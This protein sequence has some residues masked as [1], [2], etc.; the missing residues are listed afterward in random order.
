MRA[1]QKRDREKDMSMGVS[2][3]GGRVARAFWIAGILSSALAWASVGGSISGTVKD[4]T[5]RVIPGADVTAREVNTGLVYRARTGGDGH[6]ALPVLP[7]GQYELA[8]QAAG[9]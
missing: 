3:L 1:S 6:F 5:G 2:R 4:P 7:V 8:I 9:F